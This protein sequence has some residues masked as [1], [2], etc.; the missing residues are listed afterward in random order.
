MGESTPILRLVD[1]LAR[2]IVADYLTE[3][4][5]AGAAVGAERSEPVPLP[6]L[7]TAA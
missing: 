1:L 3:Q 4:A 2:E 5:N 6:P 7:D